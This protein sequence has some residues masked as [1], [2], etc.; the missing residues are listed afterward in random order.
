M[1]KYAI[2]GF[3][4]YYLVS[5]LS[6]FAQSVR[7][8]V[9]SQ[10]DPLPFANI[11]V[12]GER[13]GTVADLE[14]QFRINNV[15]F[16]AELRVSY[17]GYKPKIVRVQQPDSIS[18][19]LVPQSAELGAVEVL[20]GVNPALRLIRGVMDNRKKNDHENL[21]QY[22]CKN[23]NKLRLGFIFPDLSES[24]DTIPESEYSSQFR[25]LVSTD[26]FLSESVSERRYRKPGLVTEDVLATRTS[27]FEE[28]L[29]AVL[30]AQFQS[31]TFYNEDFELLDVTYISPIN[32][33]L[34]RHYHYLITDTMLVNDGLDTV[35]TIQFRPRPDRNVNALK[36]QLQV[37]T[38]DMAIRSVTAEPT[39][40]PDEGVSISIKQLYEKTEAWFPTQ[41]HVDM[42]FHDVVS[43]VYIDTAET[44]RTKGILEGTIRTYL[45]DIDLQEEKTLR[46]VGR[47]SVR[48]NDE[49]ANQDEGFWQGKRRIPLTERDNRTYTFIDSVGEE[50]NF[51]RFA[52]GLQAFSDGFIR[53]PYVD[54]DLKKLMRFNAHEGFYLGLGG[55]TNYRLSRKIEL[56][57]HGGYGF[58]DRVWKYGYGGEVILHRPSQLRL[59]GQYV[60]DIQEA[61]R[62]PFDMVQRGSLLAAVSNVRQYFVSVFD[63][64]SSAQVYLLW[65]P[66]PKWKNRFAVHRENRFIVGNAYW[67]NAEQVNENRFEN[68]FTYTTARW[69][70]RWAPREKLMENRGRRSLVEPGFPVIHHRL[71]HTIDEWSADAGSFFRADVQIDHRHRSFLLGTFSHRISAGRTHGTVPYSYLFTPAAN[72]YVTD[73]WLPYS[74]IAD[75]FA[76]ETM[77]FNQLLFQQYVSVMTRWNLEQRLFRRNMAFPELAF[78]GK[79]LIGDAPNHSS[80]HLGLSVVAPNGVLVEYGV[81]LLR[82]YQKF[83]V[84]FYYRHDDNIGNPFDYRWMIKLRVSI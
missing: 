76:W 37:Q 68:G 56:Y 32:R 31:F 7:G 42:L 58:R 78:V 34:E 13:K 10:R 22:R 23:Y 29:F 18:V 20:S 62:Q 61:G 49:A 67:F 80:E 40:M 50:F 57:G 39:I 16:P 52:R 73:S 63:Q 14:G 44:V 21:K 5:P 26:F 36:G 25:F 53:F 38:P 41:L 15:K 69:E 55:R 77:G 35:F 54:L 8:N 9:V 30:G 12:V 60:F 33:S 4:T 66:T 3:V 59:G 11:E 24:A 74:T 45:T 79:V 65:Q 27:G 75:E 6:V 70:S 47:I 83:G 43:Q 51:D 84:G 1:T 71:E 28:P 82:V 2:I 48:I 64:L 17:I 81:E 46:D 72:L 19:V